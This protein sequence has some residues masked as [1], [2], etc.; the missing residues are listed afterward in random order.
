M[1]IVFESIASNDP[2]WCEELSRFANFWIYTVARVNDDFTD[3]Y[4]INSINAEIIDEKLARAALFAAAAN[5]M[6]S[7]RQNTETHGN[8][9]D[10]CC[11]DTPCTFSGG[12]KKID[13]FLTDEDKKNAVNFIKVVLKNYAIH[14]ILSKQERFNF[15]TEVDYCN[16]I[17]ECNWVMYNYLDVTNYNTIGTKNPKYSITFI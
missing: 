16:S 5:G 2:R 7:L 6:I 13:Y 9:L 3:N 1:F 12:D 15:V 4:D 17:E 14:H 11:E 10:P 8:L